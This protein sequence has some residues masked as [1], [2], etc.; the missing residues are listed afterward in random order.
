VKPKWL[1]EDF[2]GKR[3]FLGMRMKNPK[4]LIENFT[5]DNGYED[6]IDEVKKQG[7]ECH[8]LDIRNHFTLQ[9]GIFQPNDCMVFQ[10][11]IQL[12]DKLREELGPQGCR[13]IGWCTEENYLCTNYYP[14]VQKLLFNDHFAFLPLNWLKKDKWKWYDRFG[15]EALIFV[16]PDSGKKSFTGQ[17]IDL[18]DFDRFF[19][20]NSSQSNCKDT[21]IVIVSSPKTIMGEWRFICTNKKEIVAYSTY[22]YQD[23]RTYIPSAPQGAIDKCKEVLETG[24]F[25]DSIFTMDICEDADGNFWLLEFNSFTSAGTYAANKEKIV[26]RVSEI[27]GEEYE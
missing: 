1:I 25:P 27:A 6:L 17:L 12:F 13:P 19:E 11:S 3:Q 8:V 21:D 15:K 9:P 2:T 24:Y 7:Y 14:A 18:Q 4:W 10:G 20:D 26:K 23:Q 22:K 5:G 16:R